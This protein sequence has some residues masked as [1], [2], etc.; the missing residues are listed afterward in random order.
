MGRLGLNILHSPWV[1]RDGWGQL[2]VSRAA[3]DPSS[4][5]AARR[6]GA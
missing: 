4:P 5:A 6:R 3:D 2:A 1:L